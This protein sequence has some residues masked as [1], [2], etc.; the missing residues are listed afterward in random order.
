MVEETSTCNLKD[1]QIRLRTKIQADVYMMM[2]SFTGFALTNSCLLS[3][4]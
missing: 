3:L 4:T 1:D 2:S